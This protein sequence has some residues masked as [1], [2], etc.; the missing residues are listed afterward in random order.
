MRFALGPTWIA[1]RSLLVRQCFT[2]NPT[3]VVLL[4]PWMLFIKHRLLHQFAAQK[5]NR[6]L[7][8]PCL[9]V[10]GIRTCFLG[11]PETNYHGWR[12]KRVS[13]AISLPEDVIDGDSL[14]VSAVNCKK[15]VGFAKIKPGGAVGEG[16]YRLKI[17]RAP[18]V[19]FFAQF[20]FWMFGFFFSTHFWNKA[21]Q[22]NTLLLDFKLQ[23]SFCF[24]QPKCEKSPVQYFMGGRLP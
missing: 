14:K 9:K 24:F 21:H 7:F 12:I 23:I 15:N 19:Y 17:E 6:N 18:S 5:K 4:W 11:I 13:P 2:D 8:M 1:I 3:W 20:I 16:Q 22:V 10:S